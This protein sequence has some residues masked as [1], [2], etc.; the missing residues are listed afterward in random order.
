MSITC[1]HAL[2]A[3]ESLTV[4]VEDDR[5]QAPDPS[6]TSASVTVLPI[7]ETVSASM[8]L[9][10]LVES[11]TGTTVVRLGGLGDYT[12]VSIRG[13]TARQV[14]VHLDGIPLNPD[15]SGAV[16]L[17]ELPLGA[18]ERVEVWRGSAPPAFGSLPIGGVVNLVT[19]D[20][21][22]GRMRLD[23]GSL[24]T[25][26]LGASAS[27]PVLPGVDALVIADAFHTDG[28]FEYFDDNGTI[29]NLFDDSWRERANNDTQQASLTGR[30]RADAG[31]GSVALLHTTLVREEGFP[32]HIQARNEDAR[33]ET[34]RH[35]TAL[36]TEQSLAPVQLTARAW[37]LQRYTAYEDTSTEGGQHVAEGTH[38]SLGVLVSAG[39]ARPRVS[40]GLTLSAR[41]EHFQGRDLLNAVDS[42]PASRLALNGAVHADVVLWR[43]R[44]TI[45]PVLA[46]ISLTDEQSGEAV[47]RREPT[48]RLGLLVRPHERV[49]LKANAGRYLRPPDFQ[50]L[51]G[52]NG[53][54]HGNDALRPE[55]GVHAD[56]SA[57]ATLPENR[58]GSAALDL[59][60]FWVV[61]DDRIVL[62]QNSQR[63]SVPTN[64]GETWV[65][66]VEAALVLDT[67]WL[68]SQSTVT[69]TLSVNLDPD[70]AYWQNQLPRMPLWE[71][72]QRTSLHLD[73]VLRV[74]HG[75][76]YTDGNFWDATNWYESPPRNLHSVFLR[77]QPTPAWPSLEASVLNLF[78]R[79][80]EVVPRNRLDPDDDGR[81]VQ[82]TTD[83]VGFPLP[84]RTVLVSLAWEV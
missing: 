67:A 35:L 38:D 43:E 84:G 25:V 79:Q 17:S 62:V 6:E 11:A 70:D 55:R 27:A 44:I 46:G 28:A 61:S 75:W 39:L 37:H 52:D 29:Y 80:V 36:Q 66:G 59:G 1:S 78:D 40:P 60:H 30:L 21:D 81:I 65:Q 72:S 45:S 33:L 63:T 76:S 8:D 22:H 73:E 77:A 51:F 24:E 26:R 47:D 82:P 15:G 9:G 71:L 83:F 14:Q 16:D 50:E 2:A 34:R 64:L 32:G 68:D 57:R 13:S 20:R 5:R 74:G 23:G 19:G 48:P 58:W 41:R 56:V 31:R 3:D 7:D 4:I 12:T 53:S 54:M 69:R 42:D 18:F 49:A 10:A